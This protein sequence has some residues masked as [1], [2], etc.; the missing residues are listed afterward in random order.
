MSWEVEHK[1]LGIIKVGAYTDITFI[2]KG[3]EKLNIIKT[4]TSCGCTSAEF[5]KDTNILMAAFRAGAIPQHLKSVGQYITTKK[6]EVVTKEKTYSLTF[7]AI[8]KI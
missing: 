7:K 3:V 6:I 8:V 5:D 2:W 4:S 1:D